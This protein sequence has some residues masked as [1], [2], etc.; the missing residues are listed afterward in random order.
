LRILK[1]YWALADAG[2]TGSAVFTRQ[3]ATWVFFAGSIKN[4]SRNAKKSNGCK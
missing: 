2:D 1:A 3:C 4:H